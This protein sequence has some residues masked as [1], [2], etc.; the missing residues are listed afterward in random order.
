MVTKDFT[1]QPKKD[2][3]KIMKL[4]VSRSLLSDALRKVQSLASGKHSMP[5]LS[6]V[7]IEAKGDK[8]KFTTTDLD[9]SVVVEISCSVSEEGAVTLPAKLMSDAIARA[10]EGDVLIEVDDA[11][12]KA[13]IRAGSSVFRLSGLPAA[14]F[15]KLPDVD[16]DATSF[17]IP[18]EVLK[19][20]FRRTAYAMSNDDTRRILRGV[21]VKYSDGFLTL[22][23]TD[24]RRLAVAEYHP[25]ES[26]TFEMEYTL[27]E[28][29]IV[30]LIR[31][32]GSTGDIS[33]AQGKTQMV[34]TLDSG[35]V[36]Y[37]KLLD[38][39]YPNY[40]AVIPQDNKIEIVVDRNLLIGA[41]ERVGI[42]SEANSMKFDIGNGM[43]RLSSSTESGD[44]DEPVPVKYTGETIKASFNHGYILD[45]LKALD[46]D[47]VVFKFK[48]GQSPVSVSCSTP[49]IA[50]IMPLRIN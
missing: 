27:P 11:T 32:L 43:I 46:D 19:T 29:A 40:A 7:K 33:F 49:G 3:D 45:A 4:T 14:E 41:I 25:E 15:P 22:A 34:A 28:K 37:S 42:F 9:M 10:A 20:L 26:F 13:V 5:I 36:I 48:D 21:H 50:V 24:G 1:K 31:H 6:N 30:E 38:D 12:N 35:I 47:E 17:K 16:A 18:Q 23:A 44:S 39:A 2:K 8:A